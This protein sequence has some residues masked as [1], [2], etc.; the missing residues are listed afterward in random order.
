MPV[1]ARAEHRPIGWFPPLLVWRHQTDQSRA[2]RLDLLVGPGA[3]PF[4]DFW[5]TGSLE[6]VGEEEV[7]DW[8]RMK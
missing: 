8:G 1:A 5:M 3:D 6:V 2:P 7:F 4:G